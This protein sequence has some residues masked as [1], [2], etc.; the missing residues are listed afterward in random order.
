MHERGFIAHC[1]QQLPP[2]AWLLDF[3]R[4]FGSIE[5]YHGQHVDIFDDL[6]FEGAWDGDFAA[7]GF[8][9]SVNAFGSGAV[10]G[11]ESVTLVPPSHTLE[12]LAICAGVVSNSPAFLWAYLLLDGSPVDWRSGE[13]FASILLGID[14]SRSLRTDRGALQLACHHNVMASAAGALRVVPKQLPPEFA[15]YHAYRA[16]LL[17]TV[18][19]VAANA[20]DGARGRRYAPITTI[21]SG[22]DSAA[23]AVL[24]RHL[25]GSMGLSL[26]RSQRGEPDSGLGVATALGLQLKEYPRPAEVDRADLAEAVFL[27]DGM[28]GEDYPFIAFSEML[29]GGLV[30]TGFHGD[31][32]WDRQQPPSDNIR[33]GDISGCSLGEFRLAQDFLHLPVPFIGCQRHRDLH[34]IANSEEMVPWSIAGDYDRPIPRRLAE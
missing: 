16:Y 26:E 7:G 3:S 15:D 4:G 23:C 27:S 30:L 13:M 9:N 10:I 18:E 17:E 2:L 20:A 24:A 12:S 1:L 8:A 11:A 21:S 22:Y 29:E 25:G 32:I 34:R 28:Q 6:F 31:K 19:K 33:R 14:R 5:L